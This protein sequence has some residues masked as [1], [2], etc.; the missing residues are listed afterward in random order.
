MSVAYRHYL[1]PPPRM[2]WDMVA[3][4]QRAIHYDGKRQV[5]K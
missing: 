2:N 4:R 3:N 1:N 5:T